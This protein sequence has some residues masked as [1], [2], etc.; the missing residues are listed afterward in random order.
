M[1]NFNF[2]LGTNIIYDNNFSTALKTAKARLKVSKAFIMTDP[3]L[4]ALPVLTTLTD[5]MDAIDMPYETFSMVKPNPTDISITAAAQAL[6]DSDADVV[7]GFGGGSS[8]D[9]AK[10]SAILK[11]NGGKL[12]DYYGME[13][14][15]K[16]P[17]PVITIPTTAGSGAEITQVMSIIDTEEKT[18][19]QIGSHLC[20]PPV[21]ILC[22]K[23]FADAPENITSVAGFDALTHCIEGYTNAKATPI[24][25]A[26]C[27]QAFQMIF[28]TLYDFVQNPDDE[29][30]ASCMLLGSSIAA[31][32]ISN[33][34][35]GNC[36]NIARAVG[37]RFN[38][39]HGISLAVMLPHVM[40]FNLDACTEKYA[41]CARA[42]GI[43]SADMSDTAAAQACILAI[44]DL[45]SH[46]N[47]PDNYQALGMTMDQESMD[48]IS[49]HAMKSQTLS[50]VSAGAAIKLASKDDICQLAK[51]GYGGVQVHF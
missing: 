9:T 40:R 25:D 2:F 1:K 29:E 44:Q 17:L 37:G 45:R 20:V 16:R 36:H 21:A 49:K 6:M 4:A 39:P 42:V 10:A 32:A 50:G 18:K 31:M 26:L 19:A 34:G 15:S 33:I 8:M 35:T 11:T 38:I 13:L 24:T 46:L 51:D 41:N 43:A 47:M 7:I 23:V 27:L 28:P 48:S 5:A 12:S 3:G 14:V 30:L 22:P